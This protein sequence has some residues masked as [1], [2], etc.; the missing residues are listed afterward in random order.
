MAGAG[1]TQESSRD[2]AAAAAQKLQPP[3]KKSTRSCSSSAS[4]ILENHN[5]HLAPGFTPSGLVPA[6]AGVVVL[7]GPLTPLP[8][9]GAAPPLPN[10]L[11]AGE[12]PLPRGPKTPGLDSAPGDSSFPPEHRQ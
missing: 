2:R 11:P 1:R 9:G 10:V 6:P 4:G 8:V 12:P 3:Q 7:R 5:T